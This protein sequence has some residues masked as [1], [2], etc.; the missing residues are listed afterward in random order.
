MFDTDHSTSSAI[1]IHGMDGQLYTALS[2]EWPNVLILF[3]ETNG[4]CYYL[5]SN[6]PAQVLIQI[7]NSLS[8]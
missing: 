1:S 3:D 7:A 4:L 5:E 2:A 6:E 8:K